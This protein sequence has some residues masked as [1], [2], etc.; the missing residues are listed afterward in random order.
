MSTDFSACSWD[1]FGLSRLFNP[2]A[3]L[4]DHT[5]F[6]AAR[7]VRV[8]NRRGSGIR[9]H[10]SQLRIVSRGTPRYAARSDVL[11]SSGL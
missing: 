6:Q 10:L 1:Y 9:A 4:L 7:P 11:S 8:G 2:A 3:S 5:R